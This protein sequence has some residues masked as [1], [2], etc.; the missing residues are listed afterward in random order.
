[1]LC[2]YRMVVSVRRAL[3]RKTS[4]LVLDEATAAVDVETDELIQAT[5]RSE[6]ADCMVLKI[7]HRLNT[8]VDS[9]RSALPL[10]DMYCTVCKSKLH[11]VISYD[12]L[13]FFLSD[14]HKQPT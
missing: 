11:R 2:L 3:L 14:L 6:F 8:V 4:I 13:I 1:M 10:Y 12:H 5:I 7:A 9:D